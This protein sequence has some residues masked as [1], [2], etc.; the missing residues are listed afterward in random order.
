M[1][2]ISDRLSFDTGID[3]ILQSTGPVVAKLPETA[4]LNLGEVRYTQQLTKLLFPPSIEQAL[5]ESLRPS[6]EHQEILEPTTNR[7][8]LDVSLGQL[9]KSA[10]ERAGTPEGD[11]LQRAVTELEAETEMCELLS[12]CRHMLHSA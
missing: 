11:V 2:E 4:S 5:L 10:D 7:A 3:G 12:M 8:T 9:R 6:I 1:A